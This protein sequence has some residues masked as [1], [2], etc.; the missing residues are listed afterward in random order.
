MGLPT[1]GLTPI[2]Q[3]V[4]CPGN[5]CS[6]RSSAVAPGHQLHVHGGGF[7]VASALAVD[8]QLLNDTCQELR[9]RLPL[10]R[11]NENGAADFVEYRSRALL[12]RRVNDVCFQGVDGWQLPF[13]IP[14]E[15]ASVVRRRNCGCVSHV[16]SR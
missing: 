2:A 7:R 13:P 11:A 8:Q 1:S 16:Q 4:A 3:G 5:E 12:V 10:P 14:A 9:A 15:L 6:V